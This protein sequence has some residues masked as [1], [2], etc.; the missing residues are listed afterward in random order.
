MILEG[1]QLASNIHWPLALSLA[2]APPAFHHIVTL[3]SH[4]ATL[5]LYLPFTWEFLR[6]KKDCEKLDIVCDH[7][8]FIIKWD[9]QEFIK[10]I[11]LSH[12]SIL[13]FYVLPFLLC[14]LP[15]PV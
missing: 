8:I 9:L 14:F 3:S 5:S 10:C 13:P 4:S 15:F 6:L 1:C 12:P 11:L 2:A 7:R